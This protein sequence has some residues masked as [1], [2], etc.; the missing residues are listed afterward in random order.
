MEP[1]RLAALLEER[2]DAE[3]S[4]ARAA[5]SRGV[6]ALAASLCARAGLDPE[7]GRAAGLAH[8]LCKEL[9]PERQAALAAASGYALESGFLSEKILHGPAAAELLREDYGVE[10]AELLASVAWHT[11][12][13]AGMGLLETFVYCADKIEPGRRDVDPAFR[14]R[15]LSLPPEEMLAAVVENTMAYLS[16]RGRAVAPETLNLY[17]TLRDSVQQT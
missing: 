7:R 8:D 6:A 4:P 10:D 11:L 12:G 15:A 1:A 13:R 5:H 14:A 3:L 9:S 2:L 17:N 16:S